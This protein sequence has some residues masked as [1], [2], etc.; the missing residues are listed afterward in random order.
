MAAQDEKY[1]TVQEFAARVGVSPQTVWKWR[2][3]GLIPFINPSGKRSIRIP[4]SAL[5][6]KRQESS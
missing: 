5:D 2:R 1:L 4:E 6:M 3:A